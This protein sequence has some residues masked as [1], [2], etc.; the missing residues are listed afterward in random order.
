MGHRKA[1]KNRAK[2]IDT[3]AVSC[4]G[5]GRVRLRASHPQPYR[6]RLP[7]IENLAA[8][9]CLT[10]VVLLGSA[11]VSWSAFAANDLDGKASVCECANN[12]RCPH[13]FIFGNGK[14]SKY[15]V[16]GYR[17]TKN[18]DIPYYLKGTNKVT[19]NPNYTL[20]TTLYRETPK[21]DSNQYILST[22]D[23]VREDSKNL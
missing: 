13:D 3:T 2:E 5:L 23:G 20:Y 10:V 7:R 17:V 18:D 14:A 6:Y 15:S 8:T 12:T 1:G 11:G 9:L 22:K 21:V 16:N 4:T 19:W